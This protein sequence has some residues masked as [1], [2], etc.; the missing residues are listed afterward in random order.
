MAFISQTTGKPYWINQ[1]T[2]KTQWNEPDNYEPISELPKN[3]VTIFS[4]KYNRNYYYNK[5]TQETT[6]IIPK[7]I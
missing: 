7:K 1:T 4:K 5:I 6:W 3:W 2:N